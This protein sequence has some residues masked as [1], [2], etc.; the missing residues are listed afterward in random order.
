MPGPCSPGEQLSFARA[1]CLAR[2]SI[3][4]QLALQERHRVGLV[5]NLVA[6]KQDDEDRDYQVAGD[7]V[8]P[9]KHRL[10][11]YP[12]VGADKHDEK[13]DCGNPRTVG[14]ESRFELQL[15]QAAA[16]G[17]PGPAKAQMTDRDSEP[18]QK[19][20]QTGGVVENLVDLLLSHGR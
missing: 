10:A 11:E 1:T 8:E 9:G 14:E 15:L 16:L 5:R 17:D 19:A 6:Q 12:G 13:Q 4:I 2:S 20:A 18:D 7:E 3:R